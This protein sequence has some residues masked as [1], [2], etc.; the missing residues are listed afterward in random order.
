M[1]Q[2]IL[3]GEQWVDVA[4][5]KVLEILSD[6][7][8]EKW[9][10][11]TI[12]NEIQGARDIIT[13]VAKRLSD[14]DADRLLHAVGV[15]TFRALNVGSFN[16]DT[17]RRLLSDGPIRDDVE[18]ELKRVQASK[19]TKA[20]AEAAA[21]RNRNIDEAIRSIVPNCA[22]LKVSEK[23]AL[24]LIPDISRKLGYSPGAETVKKRIAALK[25][26]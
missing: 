16:P 1:Q 19:G 13:A 14:T 6:A 25:K 9:T 24:N 11:C 18:R 26:G 7:G 17:A 8:I 4:F 3:S 12:L 15:L 22:D 21:E 5:G 10:G 20:N 2:K 23:F